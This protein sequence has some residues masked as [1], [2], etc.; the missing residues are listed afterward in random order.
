MPEPAAAEINGEQENAGNKQAP[1]NGVNHILI[2]TGKS[3][4]NTPMKTNPQKKE[5][6]RWRTRPR[7]SGEKKPPNPPAAPTRPVTAPTDCGKYSGTNLKTAPLP[8][9]MAAA[10]PRAPM[11]NSTIWWEGK[12]MAAMATHKNTQSRILSPPTL[13]ASH[14][15]TGRVAVA[16][17]TKPAVRIPASS[18]VSWNISVRNMGR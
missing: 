17:T 4:G 11:V 1:G 14:P 18:G 10:M 16:S 7:T 8:N 5:P 12:K 15:P 3:T 9:P 13:S 2:K 6:V